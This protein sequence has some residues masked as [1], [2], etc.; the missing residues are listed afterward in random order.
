MGLNQFSDLLETEFE[1]LMFMDEETTM[2]QEARAHALSH[3]KGFL[4]RFKDDGPPH[5]AA[6]A[7]VSRQNT[8]TQQ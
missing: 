4:T 8:T 2:A 1:A 3:R 5:D 6:T 7:R